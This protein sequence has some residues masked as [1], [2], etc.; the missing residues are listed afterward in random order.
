MWEEVRKEGEV[1]DR[2]R[3]SRGEGREVR[4]EEDWE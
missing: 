3:E 2:R 1:T 4:I